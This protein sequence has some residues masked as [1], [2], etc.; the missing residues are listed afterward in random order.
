MMAAWT[1]ANGKD[2][3]RN[4]YSRQNYKTR[5][6]TLAPDAALPEIEA[7]LDRD[8]RERIQRAIVA[9]QGQGEFRGGLLVAYD[10]AC[11][12]TGCAEE[13]VLEAA[14]IKPYLGVH[15]N[16]V[17]N[18]LLLRADIH[19]L[20]DR[21]LL[22]LDTAS[23]PPLVVVAPSVSETTYRALHGMRL[24]LPSNSK[25]APNTDALRQHRAACQW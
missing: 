23:S 14:H 20:F 11:A 24:R 21:S 19:T 17:T 16:S 3:D 1:K 13:E 22:S 18:G 7:D 6:P 5:T 15:T 4:P 2:D 9:R 25:L 8:A 10:S 12:I